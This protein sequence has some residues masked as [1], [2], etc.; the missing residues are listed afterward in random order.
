MSHPGTN[1]SAKAALLRFKRV[2][3]LLHDTWRSQD[4]GEETEC[5][6][7]SPVPRSLHPPPQPSLLPRLESKSSPIP[8]ADGVTLLERYAQMAR[9]LIPS[10]PPIYPLLS[11]EDIRLMG[12]HPVAAGG[13]ADIL[14]A[15]HDGRK[16]VLK[17]Y[18]CYI[19]FDVAQVVAVRYN[20]VFPVVCC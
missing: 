6:L 13:F 19:L 9:E 2:F 14:E 12:G 11:P 3:F 18:R 1:G 5:L 8:D 10:L 15:T 20:L 4:D 17:S 7:V 16:V